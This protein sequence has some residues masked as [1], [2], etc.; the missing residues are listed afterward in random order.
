MYRVKH[1][2]LNTQDELL[3]QSKIWAVWSKMTHNDPGLTISSHTET[4]RD[5]R[6]QYIEIV[7]KSGNFNLL[8]I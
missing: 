6:S 3:T 5:Q 1:Q 7:D 2:V 4:Y 8:Q